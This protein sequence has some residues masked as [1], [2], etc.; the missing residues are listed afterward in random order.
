MLKSQATPALAVSEDK[1][2]TPGPRLHLVH[3]ET[4]HDIVIH[5]TISP[6]N[7]YYALSS[8]HLHITEDLSTGITATVTPP[9]GKAAFSQILKVALSHLKAEILLRHQ[10]TL[11]LDGA[12]SDQPQQRNTEETTR[13]HFTIYRQA[14]VESA[15][16]AT[17]QQ[18]L[19][20]HEIP[21]TLEGG[22]KQK[23]NSAIDRALTETQMTCLHLAGYSP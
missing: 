18:V 17:K 6:G 15:W 7:P 5:C 23:V 8:P 11:S 13:V 22:G 19:P 12:V 21:F 4:N 16:K 3:S 1:P 2:K 20:A 14:S 9:K 10:R